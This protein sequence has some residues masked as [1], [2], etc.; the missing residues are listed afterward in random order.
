M[1]LGLV[2]EGGASR[3]IFSSGVMDFLLDQGIYAD[4]IIGV[5]AGI[6]NGM[7]YASR[8]KGRALKIAE[9]YMQD[10]NYMGIKHLLNPKKRCYYNLDFVFG[11]VPNEYIPFDHD[12]YA[13]SGCS[14]IAG[15]TNIETGEI[16]YYPVPHNDKSWALL[17]ASCALPI[18]FR[19]V[20]LNGK[21]YLDG[22]I[23][24]PIPVNKALADG[25]DKTI[26]I[27]TREKGYVKEKDS[28]AAL[29]ARIYKKYPHIARLLANRPALYNA[30]TENLKNLS[31]SGKVF[32]IAPTDT[33]TW[34]RTDNS[35]EKIRQ[36]YTSGYET[37]KALLPDL[38][39]YLE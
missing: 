7:S 24:D 23:G 13:S 1:K 22:G 27:T 18:L 12:A 38:L 6:S 31:D 20:T 32:W 16:E 26:V 14:A 25:C 15:V 36:I 29:S 33:S 28:G 34:S 30:S 9:N 11:T 5:S 21:K 8:Q 37:A 17:I 19:P 10:P 3:A 39:K 35:P 4:Y 2:L